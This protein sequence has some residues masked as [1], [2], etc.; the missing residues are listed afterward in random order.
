MVFP[1]LANLIIITTLRV[2]TFIFKVHKLKHAI[3]FHKLPTCALNYLPP[4]DAPSKEIDVQVLLPSAN[5]N[6]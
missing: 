5:K 2:N 6:I 1:H 3:I 4:A